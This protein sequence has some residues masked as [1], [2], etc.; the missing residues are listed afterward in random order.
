MAVVGEKN[1]FFCRMGLTIIHCLGTN[2][3]L[4]H[5]A[6]FFIFF[7]F[8]R[9]IVSFSESG[10]KALKALSGLNLLYKLCQSCPDEKAFD[11]VLTRL[12]GVITFCMERRS[13]PVGDGA[14]PL[15]FSLPAVSDSYLGQCYLPNSI[16]LNPASVL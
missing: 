14:S 5:S 2:L 6:Y 7:D 13:L 10:R 11:S 1:W 15:K 8:I 4:G 9:G 16:C 12:C 3:S